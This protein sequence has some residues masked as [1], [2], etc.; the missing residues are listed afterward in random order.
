M[1]WLFVFSGWLEIACGAVAM[2]SPSSLP[3]FSKVQPWDEMI[4]VDSNAS[5]LN[6]CVWLSSLRAKALRVY[7]GGLPP[8]F[9]SGL[10]PSWQG[11]VSGIDQIF[12]LSLCN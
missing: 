3:S 2:I 7:A 4:I 9:L 11:M 1:W 12:L 5:N 6:V 10:V 8:S